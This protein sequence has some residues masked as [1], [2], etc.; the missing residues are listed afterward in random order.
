MSTKLAIRELYFNPCCRVLPGC[1]GAAGVLP[2]A[3]GIP[4]PPARGTSSQLVTRRW[5]GAGLPGCRVLP[6]TAGLPG[7]CRV[8]AGSVPGRGVGL[9]CRVAG[10]RGQGSTTPSVFGLRYGVATL[11]Y[12][13]RKVLACASLSVYQMYRGQT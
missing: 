12:N 1:R 2:G 7:R 5:V 8:G 11:I 9:G 6:G 10:P 3:P 4:A 13:T